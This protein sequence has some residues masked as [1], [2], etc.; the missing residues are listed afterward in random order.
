M[1]LNMNETFW[2]EARKRKRIYILI[3]LGWIPFALFTISFL[4]YVAGLQPGVF[5][6]LIVMLSWY[7]LWMWSA[8]QFR[9]LEC[10]SCHKLAFENTS[11]VFTKM[12]CKNC[13]FSE[14]NN[15]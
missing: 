14:V 12:K 4:V 5:L 2:I 6:G 3:W 13:G 11:I 1:I 9:K 15:V 10:P 8:R 7:S